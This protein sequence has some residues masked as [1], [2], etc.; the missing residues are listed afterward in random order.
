MRSAFLAAVAALALSPTF[1]A[2]QTAGGAAQ[3][4]APAPAAH[5]SRPYTTA[6]TDIGSLMDDPD[7][8]AIVEKYIPGFFESDQIDL[9]RNMTLKDVQQYAPDKVT[10]KVLADIDIEFAKLP[11]KA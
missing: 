3:S 11:P 6:T 9:A 7:A 5:A 4:G 8:H 1:A 2:A 10:D